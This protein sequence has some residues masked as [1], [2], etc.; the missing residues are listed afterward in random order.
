MES[1]R[2]N[3]M[4]SVLLGD[5]RFNYRVGGVCI[6]GG[7]VL[8]V[9]YNGDE[10]VWTLPGGRVETLE[11]SSV[12]LVRELREELG[13]AVT[14]DRLLWVVENL[15][16][17]ED[18]HPCHELGLYYAVTLPPH[19][20]WLDTTH[21][22]DGQDGATRLTFRWIPLAALETFPLWPRFLRTQL[23]QLPAHPEHIVQRDE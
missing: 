3:A 22:F 14:L 17:W 16:T 15:F 18:G 2:S 8:A 9:C 10:S 19:S 12:A 20:A 13:V 5:V 21:D 11:I 1:Q 4:I 7:R 23:S 6:T